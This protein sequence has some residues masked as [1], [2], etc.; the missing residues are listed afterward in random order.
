M[1]W[2]LWLAFVGAS[3]VLLVIP[4]PTVLTVIS[5]ALTYGKQ[6]V[7]PLAVAVALGDATALACS[8][9]GLGALLAAAPHW[10]NLIR[11][12]GGC[13]LLYLGMKMFWSGFFR[14]ADAF[15]NTHTARAK[16]FVNTYLVTALNP[17]GIIFFIA[18]L[19]QFIDPGKNT[20]KQ[21][22]ILATTFVMMAGINASCYA[23]FSA[24]A[25]QKMLLSPRFAQA[26]IYLGGVLLTLA[27]I[28]A[29]CG[30]R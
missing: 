9:L 17:K 24:A 11:I 8:L 10:F 19:P 7:A 5:Y 22:L 16:L 15:P 1:S 25:S 2:Q 6:T 26:F 28:W 4:G 20:Q 3:A 30:H 12:A 14:A 23:V 29:M 21:L 27:G 18:F 13:Y